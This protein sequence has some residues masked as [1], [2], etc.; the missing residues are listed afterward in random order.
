[1]ADFGSGFVSGFMQAKQAKLAKEQQADQHKMMMLQMQEAQIKLGA[2]KEEE[3]WQAG[4]ANA[5]KEGGLNGVID[6]MEKT[7]PEEGLKLKAM[8]QAY[9]NSILDGEY[10]KTLTEGAAKD[11]NTK[12]LTAAG[13]MYGQ[14]N[15]I[16]AKDPELA[17]QAYEKNIDLIKQLDPNAP[18][19]FDTGRASMAVGLAV[20]QSERFKA[21]QEAQQAKST[22]GKHAQDLMLFKLQGNKIGEDAIL[23]AMAADKTKQLQAEREAQKLDLQIGS[24]KQSRATTLRNEYVKNVSAQ[25]TMGEAVT[26]MES[27]ASSE[28]IYTNPQKQVAMINQYARFNSPGIVTDFDSRDAQRSGFLAGLFQ[29]KQK[30]ESG[31][32]LTPEAIDGISSAMRAQ[33]KAQQPFIQNQDDY[34]SKLAEKYGIPT[35]EVINPLFKSTNE[36]VSHGEL[37]TTIKKAVPGF[38]ES[39]FMAENIKANPGLD[40]YLKEHPEYKQEMLQKFYNQVTAQKGE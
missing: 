40:E 11:N 39:E 22:E 4:R 13:N 29:L 27:L 5:A 34:Y 32:P 38:K 37:L 35:D 28:D 20:P 25:Q 21:Q 14:L 10:R 1:M 19:K 6:Y 15:E 36:L 8:S 16:Y 9:Q 23:Q 12:A 31:S 3:A 30:A 26:K 17:Q 24:E 18:A 7:R 33:W 2:M